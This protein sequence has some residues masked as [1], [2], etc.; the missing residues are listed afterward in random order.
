MPQDNFKKILKNSFIVLSGS[1]GPNIF[2]LLSMAVFS[3]SMGVKIFGYYVLFL[4]FIEIIDKIFN[5]QTWLAFIKYAI[6]FQARKE[7]NNL[8]MLLKY[9]FL[10]DFL[11][12]CF[13]ITIAYFSVEPFIAF[14][15]IPVEYSHLVLIMAMS[16]F[17][18]VFDISIGI[19]RVFDEFKVQSKI[20]VSVSFIKFS[21]FSFVAITAPSFDNFVYAMIFAQFI[22]FALKLYSSK[23]ILNDN[24]YEVKNIISKTVDYKV[25]NDFNILSF[26]VYNNFNVAVRMISRQLDIVILGKLYGTEVVGIYRI[27]KEVGGIIA[28]VTDPIYQTI[29]P[30]LA[31]LLANGKKYEAKELAFKVSQYTGLAGMVGYAF[32]LIFGQFAISLAFGSDFVGAYEIVIIYFIAIIISIITL[33]LAPMLYSFGL[34]K[35]ALYNQVIATLVYGVVIYPLA[36]YFEAIGAAVAY[37]IFY[38]AWTISTMNTINKRIF[39]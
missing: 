31:K 26:I 12:L 35:E 25:I 18:N 17:F 14:F 33:P 20:A 5:F 23:K 10:I 28:R 6:D 29:Y 8:M 34:A 13:A 24:G 36:F 2:G 7:K 15:D 39:L 16:I 32:F 9:C 4:T 19:F 1:V 27:A 21:G 37:I 38:L 22:N 11:S 30:E 3:H